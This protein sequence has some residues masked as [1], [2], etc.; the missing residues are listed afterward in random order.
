ML[1]HADDP[2]LT[3]HRLRRSRVLCPEAAGDERERIGVRQVTRNASLIERF[4]F[5]KQPV[6]GLRHQHREVSLIW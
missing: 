6:G 1:W 2:E 5:S 4:T 3:R